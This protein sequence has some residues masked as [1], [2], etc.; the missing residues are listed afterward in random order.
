MRDGNRRHVRPWTP[1]A[2]RNNF[3]ASTSGT[4]YARAEGATSYWVHNVCVLHCVRHGAVSVGTRA[5][6]AH[7]RVSKRARPVE[8]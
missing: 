6:G 7:S 3:R 1:V 8:H 5:L 2:A 4:V